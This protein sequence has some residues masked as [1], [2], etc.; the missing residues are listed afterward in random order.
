MPS[1]TPFSGD[2]SWPSVSAKTF[3]PRPSVIAA[4]PASIVELTSQALSDLNSLG[5]QL[6]AVVHVAIDDAIARAE[7][8]RDTAVRDDADR[9]STLFVI[10]VAHKELYMRV[11]WP[12]EGGS[13]TL[14][15]HHAQRTISI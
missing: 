15:G 8:L 10:P 12:C 11:G 6:N 5:R 9:S 1:S 2:T 7:G 13:K 4:D 3:R 14:A